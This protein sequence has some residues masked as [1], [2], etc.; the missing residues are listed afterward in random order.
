VNEEHVARLRKVK[1]RAE[2]ATIRF[3]RRD[4]EGVYAPVAQGVLVPGGFI[5]TAAHC[6]NWDGKGDMALGEYYFETI[7]ASNG[8][9]FTVSPYA[10]EPL[11]D[12]AALA[13]VDSQ[14]LGEEYRAFKQFCE[15]TEPVPIS[16]N[17]LQVGKTRIHVLTHTG[18]WVTGHAIR[19]GRQLDGTVAAQFDTLIESGTSGS[20]AINDKGL[21][22]GVIS[23]VEESAPYRHMPRPH[24]ALPVW[25]V[26][27]I[28]EAQPRRKG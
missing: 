2:K 9:R 10:I 1:T 6:I 26:K 8:T 4:E 19:F 27:T 25:V 17:N 3:L 15:V 5:I 28:R 21:L 18:Q 14:A 13:A 22:I 16:T 24:L 7:E 23:V 12:I 11:T 20:P